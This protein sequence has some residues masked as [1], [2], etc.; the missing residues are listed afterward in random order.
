MPATQQQGPEAPAHRLDALS[1]SAPHAHACVLH[2]P[3]HWCIK[4]LKLVECEKRSA[5]RAAVCEG[6]G[7]GRKTGT[8]WLVEVRTCV[9]C[10]IVRWHVHVPL[11]L[12]PRG[13][14]PLVAALGNAGGKG[15]NLFTERSHCSSVPR[16]RGC[17]QAGGRGQGQRLHAG[18]GC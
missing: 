4:Q 12:L 17:R 2:L 11:S 9:Q 14:R 13:G 10:R 15:G 3:V 16:I 8:G 18:V 6:S 5:A 7:Q 1:A